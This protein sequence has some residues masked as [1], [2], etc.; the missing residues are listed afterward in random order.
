MLATLFNPQNSNDT[1][2][3]NVLC[4]INLYMNIGISNWYN[5]IFDPTY[6]KFLTLFQSLKR[7]LTSDQLKPFSTY[8][9]VRNGET[10]KRAFQLLK[11][12][13]ENQ[14]KHKTKSVT[15]FLLTVR[16]SSMK[17]CTCH[18]GVSTKKLTFTLIFNKNNE[19]LKFFYTFPCTE[20]ERIRFQ[21][22][23]L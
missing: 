18:Y 3:I 15:D 23:C 19:H 5:W 21:S 22:V 20:T 2:F 9:G 13:K 1:E 4:H 12:R 11:M 17:D 7:L 14:L 6:L 8:L 16:S 10:W